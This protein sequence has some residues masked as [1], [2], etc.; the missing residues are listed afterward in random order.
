[1]VSIF[2]LSDRSSLESVGVDLLHPVKISPRRFFSPSTV[3]SYGWSHK[4]VV[5]VASPS[6]NDRSPGGSRLYG[7][8]G[9]RDGIGQVP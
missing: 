5:D 1:V 3:F 9:V 7:S 2:V 4:L 8:T 6:A